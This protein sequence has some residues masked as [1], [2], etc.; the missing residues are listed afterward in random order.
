[1]AVISNSHSIATRGLLVM[2]LG[3][4]TRT[5]PDPK[6]LLLIATP[7]YREDIEPRQIYCASAPSSLRIFSGN[8]TRTRDTPPTRS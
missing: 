2:N 5:T 8:K 4:V 6:H 7:H 1:M 3:Q